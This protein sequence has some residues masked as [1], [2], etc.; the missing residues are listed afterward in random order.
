MKKLLYITF[1][2][3]LSISPSLYSQKA[4]D[5]GEY[6]KFKIHYGIIN[7][8]YATVE[9]K[10]IMYQGKNVFQAKGYGWTTGLTKALFKVEDDYQTIFDKNNNKPYQFIR[11]I[12]EGGYIKN[13]QG[14]FDPAKQNVFV[15]DFK[16]NTEKT[17]DVTPNVQ[18]IMSSFYYLR[19]HPDI[20]KL[21]EGESIVIDMFFDDEIYKFRLKY[22]G[23]ENLN[24]KFGKLS[25][26]KF[27]PYVQSGRIFKEK[28]S[29]TVWVSD[30]INKVPLLI[31]A[32]LLVGSLKASLI[33]VKGLQQPLNTN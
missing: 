26:M 18:D 27:R 29:L 32:D 4:Y 14:F 6:F 12:N 20:D 25:S 8:G 5:S 13:Q 3:L 9:L 11:K 15:K 22:L 17:F 31:K 2:F 10:D 30:D 1:T 28:E 23:K 33:E 7:A 19:N 21:K 16:N 24:T